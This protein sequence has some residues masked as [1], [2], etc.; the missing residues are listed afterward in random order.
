MGVSFSDDF[1]YQGEVAEIIAD[2]IEFLD[3]YWNARD[4][5]AY[6]LSEEL[7]LRIEDVT[8][9]FVWVQTEDDI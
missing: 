3:R 9:S 8:N 5:A 7:Q 4:G 6:D 2:L 1:D